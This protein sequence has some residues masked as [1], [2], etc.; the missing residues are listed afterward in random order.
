[1]SSVRHDTMTLQE[2][3][4]EGFHTGQDLPAPE[5][6][7][8]VTA[9]PAMSVE[10][11]ESIAESSNPTVAQ[12][13]AY[14]RQSEEQGRQASLLPNPTVGYSGDQIRG[15]TFGGG[16]QG[17]YIQQEFV[18]GG[19]LGMRRDIYR[20]EAKNNQ[21][22]VEEQTLRVRNSVQQAF[23]RALADQELVVVRQR[24]LKVALDA[25][26]TAHQLENLGQ[27]DAPDVLQTEVEAEHAKIDFA[28]REY[29][30]AFNTL[31][32]MAGAQELAV[33]TQRQSGTAA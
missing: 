21:I 18:L 6:L 31:A 30:Q 2:P 7:K 28:Q 4:N 19:K 8:E 9:R 32:A 10:N 33:T 1:V 14:V 24:L 13:R 5:L 29:L 20:Q 12:A 15:G 23:Y 17:A 25:V 22:G 11:F 26:E 16:E 27:A 3:E